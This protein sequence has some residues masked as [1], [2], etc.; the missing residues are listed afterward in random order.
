MNEPRD[1]H[2]KRSQSE[3]ERHLD[4]TSRWN[5]KIMTQMN[6]SEMETNLK[7]YRTD[8]WFS[9][10]ERRIWSLGL[11][12]ASHTEWIN[13]RVLLYSTGNYIQYLVIN[14]NAKEYKKNN[15][16]NIYI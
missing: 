8:L 7:T 1:Y 3:R 12:D 6:I 10:E 11:E 13:N 2:T 16:C 14:Q 15:I 4:I 5:L 9:R